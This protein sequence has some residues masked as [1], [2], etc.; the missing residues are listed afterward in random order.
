MAEPFQEE[1]LVDERPT[2]SFFKK[3]GSSAFQAMEAGS[4]LED[5][6]LVGAKLSALSD[7][8]LR[9]RMRRREEML[10]DR[11]EKQ[12]EARQNWTLSR[13]QF[14]ADLARVD[15]TSPDYQQVRN[16]LL[17][18]LPP[19]ALEDDAVRSII[20][21]KDSAAAELLG[22]REAEARE[23]RL[24]DRARQEMTEEWKLKLAEVG[25]SGE[26]WDRIVED[27]DVDPIRLARAVGEKT[28]QREEE[29]ARRK[30]DLTPRSRT[31]L[32]TDVDI[33]IKNDKAFPPGYYVNRLLEEFHS[34][35]KGVPKT[36]EYMAKQP[37]WDLRYA[38]AKRKDAGLK[39]RDSVLARAAEMSEEEFVNWW[40]D[41]DAKSKERRRQVWQLAQQIMLGGGPPAAAPPS[42]SAPPAAAP[43]T[44]P[45]AAAPETAPPEEPT[46]EAAPSPKKRRLDEVDVELS[47]FKG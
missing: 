15:E 29:E 31:D 35:K 34:E 36:V 32:E 3:H 27:G 38:E 44:A 24:R 13:G 10:F 2:T 30:A 5:E 26:E 41:M 47:T 45:P 6:E 19:E 16:D 39:D 40:P 23:Q 11:E 7:S 42:P 21:Y 14:L 43:E 1:T 12:Y 20:R 22:R 25:V 17:A 37:G 8:R 46:T 4:A 33:L 28:R 9:R 18:T